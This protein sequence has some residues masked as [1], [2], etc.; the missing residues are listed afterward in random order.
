[1]KKIINGKLYDTETARELGMDCFSNSRDFHY[2]CERL[3][4]KK[5]GEFFL[6]GKGGP[7]SKYAV[8]T[9]DNGWSGG[10]KIIPL[11]IQAAREW[12]E[13]HLSA[14]EYEEIFGMPDEDAEPVALNLMINAQLMAELRTK[15]A[16][17]KTS[18]TA[19]LEE[20]LKNA[21]HM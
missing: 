13:E 12:T 21:L 18:V 17:K 7:L 9:G 19:C 4:R 1:M 14:D 2:W 15:A 8:S 5:T 20:I 10:E 6:Y 11:S 16:E 3:Y